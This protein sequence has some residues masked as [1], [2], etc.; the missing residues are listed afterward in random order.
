[1]NN[2]TYPIL[3]MII[4]Y[5]AIGLVGVCQ[6]FMLFSD[7]CAGILSQLAV[8][9]PAAYWLLEDARKRIYVPHVIQPM[10]V[11]F[12]MCAIPIYLLWTRKWYAFLYIALHGTCTLIVSVMGYNFCVYFVWPANSGP[13]LE[14]VGP[15][16]FFLK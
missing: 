4:Y 15:I 12:W 5:F 14:E 7:S 13:L 2:G 6:P 11:S 3:W 9:I 10:L 1:M 16:G 8:G